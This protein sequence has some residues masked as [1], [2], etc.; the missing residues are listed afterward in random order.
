[1]VKGAPRPAP[2]GDGMSGLRARHLTRVG[3]ASTSRP[4][5][6]VFRLRGQYGGMA[7]GPTGLT[8]PIPFITRLGRFSQGRPP[9]RRAIR[10]SVCIR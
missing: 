1:M 10:F 3:R 7:L 4:R 5:G 2:R 8:H 6:G 9:A